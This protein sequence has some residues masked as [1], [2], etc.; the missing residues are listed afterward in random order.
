MSGGSG[1]VEVTQ[2]GFEQAAGV[3]GRA[4]LGTE[5]WIRMIPDEE[6]RPELL[7]GMFVR[8]LRMVT[9]SGGLSEQTGGGEGVG[10]WFAPGVKPTMWAALRAGYISPRWFFAQ[11]LGDTR[12]MMRV[13]SWFESFHPKLL[14]DP[15]WYLMALG[16]DPE[17]HG[18]GFGSELVRAGMERADRDGVAVYLE[19]ETDENVGYYE[20]LGF[21][22]LETAV[23]PDIDLSFAFMARQ[24]S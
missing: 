6:K 7:S 14:P 17:F 13:L 20:H 19:T 11:P 21:D 8:T 16:V 12:R 3:L 9:T 5:Q 15:H 2:E 10:L 24:P 18:R 4:F 22:V 23:N 1:V